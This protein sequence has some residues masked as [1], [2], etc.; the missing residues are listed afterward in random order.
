MK[1]YELSLN[2]LK[3]NFNYKNFCEDLNFA[4]EKNHKDYPI[5]EIILHHSIFDK[6]GKFNTI[7]EVDEIKEDEKDWSENSDKISKDFYSDK[8]KDFYD[9][10]I[11]ER[12]K[13]TL[14]PSISE[15]FELIHNFNIGT[16]NYSLIYSNF[17]KIY[18]F[19]ETWEDMN[20]VINKYNK[21]PSKE[22]II[23]F[24][25]QK[26]ISDDV[27]LDTYILDECFDNY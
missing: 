14:L 27:E 12:N 11:A 2:F 25:K 24:M 16:L 26:F 5:D 23:D 4:Y 10:F 19:F 3:N 21:K 9:W 20:V 17:N 7:Q 18:Y 13:G 15:N 8:N 22:N 1:R 6:V